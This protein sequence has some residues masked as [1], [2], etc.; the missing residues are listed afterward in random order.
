MLKGNIY[1]YKERICSYAD[2]KD[3]MFIDRFVGCVLLLFF[4]YGL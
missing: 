2:K 3:F 1:D 4:V